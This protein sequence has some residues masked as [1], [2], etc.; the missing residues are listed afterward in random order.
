MG[1][2]IRRSKKIGPFRINLSTSGVGISTGVTGARVS[3]GPRGTYVHLGRQGIYYR[4]KLDLGEGKSVIENVESIADTSQKE[5]A[6]TIS[7]FNFDELSDSDSQEFIN[8][9]EEKDKRIKF[10]PLLGILPSILI[11][12]LL[13]RHRSTLRIRTI[14]F[15]SS[16]TSVPQVRMPE[17]K[18]ITGMM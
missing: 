8:E 10:L 17:K 14:S 4:K 7:T 18:L 15:P 3:V 5:N 2:F 12:H 9:L 1:F 6:H 13:V 16:S 11:I